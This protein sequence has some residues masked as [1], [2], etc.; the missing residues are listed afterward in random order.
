MGWKRN[1]ISLVFGLAKRTLIYIFIIWNWTTHINCIIYSKVWVN[2]S[3]SFCKPGH[4]VRWSLALVSSSE[5]KLTSKLR[6][7]SSH[8][9]YI[10]CYLL[11]KIFN[12]TNNLKH[13]LRIFQTQK[14]HRLPQMYWAK[15]PTET[16]QYC[17]SLLPHPLSWWETEWSVHHPS[18]SSLHFPHLG[19]WPY[20]PIYLS[21]YL[22]V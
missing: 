10:I 4:L 1:S 9:K 3:R 22:S 13:Y 17:C 14:S 6:I 21:R 7:S 20:L 18:S 5:N 15:P 16:L 12:H 19:W 8:N 11:F 2:S